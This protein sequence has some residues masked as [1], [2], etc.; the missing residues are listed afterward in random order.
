MAPISWRSVRRPA[1]TLVEVLVVLG[2]IGILLALLLPAVQ[3]ARAAADRV[4]C[5]SRLRQVGLG[6]HGYHDAHGEF[7]PGHDW[8][9]FGAGDGSLR[10][11][12]WLAKILPFVDQEPLWE[13][14][15]QALAQDRVPWDNPPHV[16]LATVVPLFTCP[17]D[18]R[19]A[20][21]QRGPDGILAAYTSYLGIWGEYE[22]V[23]NGVLPYGYAVRIANITDGTSQT[24]M[25]GE[26]P[27]SARLDSGWWYTSHWSTYSYDTILWAVMLSQPYPRNCIASNDTY[28]REFVFGPGRIGNECD[29]Y[30]FWSLHPGGANFCLADGSVHFLPYSMRQQMRALASRNGGED[31]ELP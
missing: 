14:T 30:H 6:L 5:Q 9:V 29:M 1:V 20:S 31:V 8:R 19:V 18:P 24:A 4:S 21:P 11:T 10:G 15:R 28:P 16:G 3:Q 7:P 25:V 22:G 2:I 17:S 13:Q 26:R 27:P 12:S 23:N